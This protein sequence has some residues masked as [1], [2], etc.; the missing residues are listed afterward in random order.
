MWSEFVTFFA[1]DYCFNAWFV[2]CCKFFF[3]W[4]R[5]LNTPHRQSCKCYLDHGLDASKQ[6]NW[7][8]IT[9]TFKRNWNRFKLC[10]VRVI[11]SW[12]QITR[13]E[14]KNSVCCISIQTV[15]I[16]FTFNYRDVEWKWNNIKYLYFSTYM[17]LNKE[18]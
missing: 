17:K 3:N 6:Y 2:D 10:G 12:Q 5:C 11:G 16:L 4:T 8:L 13:N 18:N 15:N 7:L 9:Q 14:K 1:H